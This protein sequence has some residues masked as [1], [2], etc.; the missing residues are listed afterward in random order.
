MRKLLTIILLFLSITL[1]AV[2]HYVATGG[3]GTGTIGDPFGTIAQVNA[4][5][6]AAG[7]NIYF[8]RGDTFYGTLTT[9]ASGS[10]GNVITYGAYG[11]GSDPIITG[12][13]TITGWTNTGGGI[14]SKVVSC[15]STPNMVTVDGVNTPIGRYPDT[16]WLTIDSHTGT[17]A[18]VDAALGASPDWD[19]ATVVIRKNHWIIDRNTITN[20]TGTSITYTTASAYEPENGFGYFIQNDLETLTTLGEWFYSTGTLYMYFGAVDPTTKTVKIATLDKNFTDIANNN[21]YITLDNITFSGA[22]TRNI[23]VKSSAHV[24]IQNCTIEF[25][26]GYAIYGRDNG[27]T[28]A[29]NFIVQ[30]NVINQMNDFGIALWDEFISPLITGNTISNIAMIAG[31]SGSDDM[32]ANGIWLYG[33]GG[34]ISLNSISNNGY[35]PIVIQGSNYFVD[36]NFINYY[37]MVKDDGGAIYTAFAGTNREITDN[38]IMNGI[39]EATGA[40]GTAEAN[41]IYIDDQGGHVLI[42]GNSL[43]NIQSGG[44]YVHNAHDLIITNNTLLNTG[45]GMDFYHSS[46]QPTYPITGIDMDNNIVVAKGSTQKVLRML[47]YDDAAD[48]LG[49]GTSDYN[50][51]TRPILET[52]S[53]YTYYPGIAQT[54]RTLA[55]WKTYSS[56]DAHSSVSLGTAIADTA[57]INFIYNPTQINQTYNLSQ[58]MDDVANTSY[59][60]NILLEPYHSLILLGEGTVTLGGD[61]PPDYPTVTT[62]AISVLWT[63]GATSG[64]NVTDAGG[65]T[66]TARGVCWSTSVNP[67][68]SDS[69]THDGTGTGAFTS[70]ISPLVKSTTYHVR[71][72]A[73]NSAGTAYG[74]DLEFT[75]P[76]F[77]I[78]GNGT[79]I[80]T[81]GGVPIKIE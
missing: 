49:Y 78:F 39:G 8:N 14:Y 25:G 75:T 15:A 46:S 72:Y 26:G 41:G 67:T 63:R 44:I 3:G 24:T 16:G 50:Y 57:N 60:G 51:F 4:H 59:S 34:T 31:M 65:G 62:T 40:G 6:F 37:C 38:I 52:S 5:V 7:D 56:Q 73:T 35:I 28:N 11:S 53:T 19:G 30:N 10:A 66:I 80:I 29:I 1:S 48:L 9:N 22:N 20:H 23:D 21:N 68:V 36:R 79:T 74:A 13:T 61:P 76:A 71:S 64:G 2:D 33:G 42:D 12:F 18:I 54:D 81:S 27:G 55:E 43:C 70:T 47:S 17:T 58:A 32:H 69:H 77:S 45:K